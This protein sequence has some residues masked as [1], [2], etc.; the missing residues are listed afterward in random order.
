VLTALLASVLV[1][2]AAMTSAA[3]GRGSVEA[4]LV[5]SEPTERRVVVRADLDQASSLAVADARV[6]ELLAEAFGSVPVAV[7]RRAVSSSY[8]LPGRSDGMPRLGVVAAYDDL[9]EHARLLDGRWPRAGDGPRLEVVLHEAVADEL[10]L[11]VGDR[12]AGANQLGD[13]PLAARVTGLVVP[14]DPEG[15]YW[16]GDSLGATGRSAGGSFVTFG[17][18]FVADGSE[19]RVADAEVAWWADPMLAGLEPAEVE[20]LRRSVLALVED[21]TEELAPDL[22]GAVVETG[23]DDVLGRVGVPV[24]VARAAVG[25]PLTLVGLLA[26]SALV[27]LARLLQDD[28][29]AGTSLQA[30]RGFST[31]QIWRQNAVE[32]LLATVPAALLAPPL[33][34]ASLSVVSARAGAERVSSAV[35]LGPGAWAWSTLCAAVV[36]VVLL[37]RG[38]ARDRAG[39]ARRAWD[40]MGLDLVALPLAAVAVVRLVS[41]RDGAVDVASLGDPFV[42]LAVPLVLLALALLVGRAVRLALLGSA[43]V[44]ARGRGVVTSVTSWQLARRAEEHRSLLV[45]VVLAASVAA[46]AATYLGSATASHEAQAGLAVGA[47]VRVVGLHGEEAGDRLV[48]AIEET[49][50]TA[51]VVTRERT[52][53][54]G[55]AVDVVAVPPAVAVEVLTPQSEGEWGPALASLGERPGS[56]LVAVMDEAVAAEVGGSDTIRARIAGAD[57]AL[58]PGPEVDAVPGVG[59][60][61]D[62]V[63]AAAGAAVPDAGTGLVVDRAELAAVAPGVETDAETEVWAALDRARLGEVRDA[64]ARAEGDLSVQDRWSVAQAQRDGPVGAGL[65]VGLLVGVLA[66]AVFGVIA[67]LAAAGAGLRQRRTE[68]ASLRATGMSRR[69]VGLSL[70]A[71]RAVLIAVA[72]FLGVLL[73][74][75]TAEVT[76]PRLLL[77]EAGQLPTPPVSL[78]VPWAALVPA[79][80]GAVVLSTVLLAAMVH[81]VV[82]RPV[83][84]EL[85]RG[86]DT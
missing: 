45:A 60:D 35:T 76:V 54:G 19:E 37:R 41:A 12:V 67:F 47:D 30:S 68:V 78:L 33:A 10:G 46:F 17:P 26:L 75:L 62:A 8:L 9:R 40:R 34:R 14:I 70:L 52:S 56:S 28:R 39:R 42:L 23:V 1:T 29:A 18:F 6:R 48:A 72:T 44:A 50:G 64:V 84:D 20:P 53:V 24:Q 2:A 32:A 58:Q 51:M 82:K 57:V 38:A 81:G 4:V 49:G 13:E 73:G 83:G 71:E 7:T 59:P 36:T 5:R 27:L 16:A 25:L 85:R 65:R 61:A 11:E 55:L 15:G 69:Q 3:A 66:A 80:V 21:G 74:L 86:E 22:P 63:V 79:A 77:T 43:R 31:P